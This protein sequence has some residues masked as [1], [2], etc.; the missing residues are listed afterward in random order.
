MKATFPEPDFPDLPVP[1]DRGL[2]P[3]ANGRIDETMMRRLLWSAGSA[4]P[5]TLVTVQS[6]RQRSDRTPEAGIALK[7]AAKLSKMDVMNPE[8]LR[9]TAAYRA[10]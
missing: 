7:V 10:F 1:D 3:D 5:V 2:R 9:V 4:A 8:V 6:H